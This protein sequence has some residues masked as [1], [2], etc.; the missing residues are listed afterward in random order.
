MNIKYWLPPLLVTITIFGFSGCGMFNDM[1]SRVGAGLYEQTDSIGYGLVSGLSTGLA[2]SVNQEKVKKLVNSLVREMAASLDSSLTTIEVERVADRLFRSLQDNLS[3]PAFR[4][5]LSTLAG[6]ILTAAG[7][8]GNQQAGKIIDSLF[9][10]LDSEAT[11]RLMGRL[12]EELIGAET[13]AAVQR[14]LQESIASAITDSSAA[15]IRERL[16]GPRTNEAIRAIVD[17][18]MVAIVNRMNNDLNP[19]LQ[20]NISFIQK[21]ARELLII[22]GLAALGIVAFVWYQRRKYLRISSL[23]S[24]QIFAMPNQQSYDELTLR[25]KQNA[26]E[27]GLEPTLR[28]ILA[29]NGLLGQ[30]AWNSYLKKKNAG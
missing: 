13:S 8:A 1:G 28:K 2:D 3:D 12:R 10:Q 26:V 9:M 18:A 27:S 24:A 17:S 11:S 7:E 5:S 20:A 14:L 21:N 16:L 6:T 19:S 25:I 22:L 30:E 4:D 23:I 15:L 29:D